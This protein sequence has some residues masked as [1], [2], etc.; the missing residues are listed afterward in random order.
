MCF[1]GT[2]M[3]CEGGIY[4]VFFPLVFFMK[5]KFMQ[6][7]TYFAI[8]R[9]EQMLCLLVDVESSLM[10]NF[11]SYEIESLQHVATMLECNE[12]I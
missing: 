10:I 6:R 11:F 5:A 4:F 9:C 8:G 3:S 12:E 1:V 2:S 7:P